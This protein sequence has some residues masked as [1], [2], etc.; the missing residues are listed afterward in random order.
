MRNRDSRE[1]GWWRIFR[2]RKIF[3]RAAVFSWILVIGALSLY[4]AFTLL[5]QKQIVVDNLGSEAQN[6]AA[7]ISQVTAT[8][9]VAEDYSSAIDHCMKVLK[10]SPSILYVVITRND[11]FSLV[12]TKAGWKQQ[13]LGGLW[14]PKSARTSSSGFLESGLIGKEVFHFSYPFGYSGIDWGWIHIGLSLDKYRRILHDLYFR[15]AILSVAC[16]LLALATSLAFS[17]KLTAPINVLDHVTRKVAS[18]D[19]SAKADVRT[20]DELESLADSFNRMTEALQESRRELLAAQQY[21]EGIIRSLNDAL[22]V[23]DES[24]VI[25]SANTAILSLLGYTEEEILGKPVGML[26]AGVAPGHLR[27]LSGVPVDGDPGSPAASSERIYRSKD[28][29][30]IPVLFSV[31][32][33]RDSAGTEGGY[34]C[35]A[36]DITERKQTEAEL[37]R[38]KEEAEAASRAKSQFLANMSHE[39]RTPMNGILGM[40]ELLLATGITGPQRRYAETAHNSGEKLLTIINDILD[41]SKIEAGKL[42]L[43]DIDFDPGR[44]VRDVVE[45]LSVPAKEKGLTLSFTMDE[46]VPRALNGDP[47]RLHQVLVNLVGNAI[48][49]TEKGD[50]RIRVEPVS[51]ANDPPLLRFEVEDQGIGI[52]PEQQARIFEPFS[53]ADGSSTR[54]HGGTGLGLAI[55]RQLVGMMGGDIGVTSARGSGATFWFTFPA[56]LPAGRESRKSAGTIAGRRRGDQR[57]S[58]R[59]LLV[60]DNPVNQEVTEAMLA[61]LGLDVTI[62][63]NGQEALD[64]LAIG[65]YDAVLMDCQMPRMDG[66]EATGILRRR[67]S[68]GPGASRTPVIALTAHAMQGD[69]ELCLAAGM[70]DYLAKPFSFAALAEV[71]AKWLASGGEPAPA[72]RAL[73]TEKSGAAGDRRDPAPPALDSSV[74]DG[75]R[76]LE[77]SGAPGLLDRVIR[78]YLEDARTRLAALGAAVDK[79][80]AEEVRQVAHAL[81]SAS[82]NVGASILAEMFRNL[83]AMGRAGTTEGS[84]AALDAVVKEFDRVRRALREIAPRGEAPDG[85]A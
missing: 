36:M 9:I 84:R 40:T 76:G 65:R 6:I 7:S 56:R 51:G 2:P 41:F 16:I 30:E 15:T 49:F 61:N 66:Y 32:A 45:L 38:S 77:R 13:R 80:D 50:V 43:E 44:A 24:G 3:L 19:L 5:E 28:G 47:T 27:S 33:V 31:S 85:V 22:V 8:A 26:F 10:D 25:R 75:L 79:G 42:E 48:K 67:E 20:G 69:R 37:T 12:Q 78:T 81:K 63:G 62:C 52:A 23:V 14:L 53:Q 54:R 29:R 17:R 64:T 35:V 39:I 70:D 34:A 60:E 11:G 46:G 71:L 74:L 72:P 59:I 21:T 73:R 1:G 83:E 58:G 68:E 18:G 57:L 4:L 82:G 55:S